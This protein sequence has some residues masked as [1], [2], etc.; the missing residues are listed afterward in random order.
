MEDYA[1]SF[2]FDNMDSMQHGHVPFVVILLKYLKKWKAEH[3]GKLPSTYAEKNEF[4]AA[5]RTGMRSSDE[6]NFEEA[7]AATWRACTETKVPSSVQQIF[8]DPACEN[9]TAQSANFWLLTNAVKQFVNGP[10]KGLPPLAGAL[11]DMK[12]DSD[13]YV[14]LQKVYRQ[15]A[16]ADL[17]AV[18]NILAQ[19][20]SS[21][22]LKSDT[23]SDPEI[24]AFCKHAVFIKVIRYKSLAEEYAGSCAKEIA[25]QLN[26]D[27]ESI[28]LYVAVRAADRF[29]TRNA[30]RY[31]GEHGLTDIEEDLATMRSITEE[32]LTEWSIPASDIEQFN[33]ALKSITQAGGAELHNMASLMGGLVSQE[34]IKLVTRQYI[35][36][37]NTCIFDG[38]KSSASVYRL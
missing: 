2:D 17:L 19:I 21:L 23:I 8:S 6:E 7:I 24:E 31:P 20:L 15:K 4:K 37:D 38:V 36:L 28:K 12:A 14:A 30:G 35:P 29:R 13:R 1:D 16:Q 9:V 32:L 26:M 25:S 10:G 33:D 11:P 34:A 22:G 27:D 3:D 18:K 5:I